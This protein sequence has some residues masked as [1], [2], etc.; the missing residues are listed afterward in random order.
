MHTVLPCMCMLFVS[1]LVG[2][3]SDVGSVDWE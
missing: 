3:A 1:V 2:A